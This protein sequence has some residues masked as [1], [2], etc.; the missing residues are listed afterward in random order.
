MQS[1]LLR[2]EIISKGMTVK[3]LADTIGMK[4]K[5]FYNKL[6]GTSQFTVD[7]A[8]KICDVLQI[9]D[10]SKKAIIFLT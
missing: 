2:G 9:Y 3:M 6:N 8:I 7:E 10:G 1:N 4:P 5:T